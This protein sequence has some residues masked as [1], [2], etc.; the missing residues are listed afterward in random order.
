MIPPHERILHTGLI[1]G[2]AGCFLLIEQAL[3]PEL[4]LAFV[5]CLSLATICVGGLILS[6]IWRERRR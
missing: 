1:A 2:V 4:G 5:G 3:I 6:G